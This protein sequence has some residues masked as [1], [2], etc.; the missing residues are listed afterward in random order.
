LTTIHYYWQSCSNWDC[1]AFLTIISNDTGCTKGWIASIWLAHLLTK[2]NHR[3]QPVQ[4]W[5]KQAHATIEKITGQTVRDLD[6]TDD[7][8]TLLLRRLS[9][10]QV[11][12]AI[13]K[14]LSQNII[15]VYD[16]TRTSRDQKRLNHG[17]TKTQRKNLKRLRDSVSPWLAKILVQKASI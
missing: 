5:V 16:L 9:Q 4:A 7:R 3:K 12:Q 1:P 8:L 14:E 6:F 15:R 13:E 17:G 11:W 10:P 2:S